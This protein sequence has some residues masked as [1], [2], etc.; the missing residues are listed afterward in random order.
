MQPNPEPPSVPSPETADPFLE[1]HI[2]EP[3][4]R[5]P[6]VVQY[7]AL[8]EEYPLWLLTTGIGVALGACLVEAIR[9]P[10]PLRFLAAPA[11]MVPLAVVLVGVSALVWAARTGVRARWFMVNG[12]P[13]LAHAVAREPD[14]ASRAFRVTLRYPT[15]TGTCS[16]QV[17]MRHRVPQG[18]GEPIRVLYRPADPADVVVIRDLSIDLRPDGRGGFRYDGQWS[19]LALLLIPIALPLLLAVACLVEWLLH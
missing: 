5:V 19:A 4:R 10:G 18:R 17:I 12:E 15:W 3:K 1:A 16:G 2:A 8:A 11:M 13:S 14:T 9:T 6:L 7:I